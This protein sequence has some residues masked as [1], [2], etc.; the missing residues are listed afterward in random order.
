MLGS[1]TLANAAIAIAGLTALML[2]S[3]ILFAVIMQPQRSRVS[4]WFAAFCVSLLLWSLVSLTGPLEGLRFGLD[5]QG[6]AY[7]LAT[8]IGLSAMTLFA[9]CYAYAAPQG[10]LFRGLLL[11]S[12]FV[13]ATGVALIWSGSVFT[14]SASASATADFQFQPFGIIALG[15]QLVYALAAFA[16]I[17]S[18]GQTT[19]PLRLP[20]ALMLVAYA[21]LTSPALLQIPVA[22]VL[23]TLAAAWMGYVVQRRILYLPLANVQDELRV[24]NQDLRR[25]LADL[26]LER[27]RSRQ[28]ID[29]LE[30]AGR[31]RNQFIDNLALKLRTQLTLVNGYTE[32]M[33]TGAYGELNERQ[34]DRMSRL[35]RSVV[36]LNSL[37]KHMLDLNRIEAGRM[38][39]D[40]APFPLRP[41][42]E[43]AAAEVDTRRAE[44][45]LRLAIEIPPDLP[46]LYGDADRIEQV[47]TEL[48]D[49]AIKFTPAPVNGAPSPS[50]AVRARL[51]RVMD[52]RSDAFPLPVVG[53]LGDGDWIT[54]EVI[55][56]GIGIPSGEQARIFDEFTQL[57]PDSYE[58]S[59][60]GLAVCRRLV[61][62][63]DGRIWVKSQPGQGSTFFVA[64][65]PM[66]DRRSS[67]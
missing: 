35:N 2:V 51:V 27:E 52:G 41:V 66:P 22:I 57:N 64:L 11:A 37:I 61:E 65:R 9:F 42:I 20:A 26:A 15:A 49:N 59:G 28:L 55:D 8:L 40:R 19:R 54:V 45:G 56:P 23:A 60:M 25:A 14:G 4:L 36:T 31:E 44:K 58:G 39:L 24:A 7:L 67:P 6:R 32:L 53:W 17:M 62:L 50:I 48:L 3:G 21:S 13:L 5:E 63:H 34:L 33:L 10:R 43:R 47:F 1:M 12:P 46:P 30:Q 38:S 29:Q 16:I 18:G